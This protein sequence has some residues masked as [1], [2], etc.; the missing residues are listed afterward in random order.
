MQIPLV[1]RRAYL[2]ALMAVVAADGV[3]DKQEVLKLYELF[4][5]LGIDVG[6]RRKLLEELV[7]SPTSFI[8]EGVAPELLANDELKISLAKDL[9][10]M[11]ENSAN[12]A[13]LA[14][15]KRLLSS[16]KLTPDQADVI[17]KFICFEN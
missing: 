4:S 5:L 8:G 15:A 16:V 13:S 3:L 7:V 10:L 14:A 11:Q 2:G 12:N 9:S 17:K 6:E 1:E